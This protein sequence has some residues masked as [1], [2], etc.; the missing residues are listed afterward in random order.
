MRCIISSPLSSGGR[1]IYTMPHS[2]AEEVYAAFL[3]LDTSLQHRR[4]IADIY[5][6]SIDPSLIVQIARENTRSA[7][8]R[9]PLVVDRRSGLLA[10]LSQCGISIRDIWYDAPIA[11]KRLSREISIPYDTIPN[12]LVL[13]KTIINLPTHEGI[14][15][16]KAEFIAERIMTWHRLP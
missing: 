9:F 15:P 7:E 4:M 12:A 14:T 6:R 8:L 2:T 3:V 10:Y 13:T 16:Q 11:P 1:D 5:R